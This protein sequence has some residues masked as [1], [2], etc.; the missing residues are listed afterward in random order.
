MRWRGREHRVAAVAL[1][2]VAVVLVAVDHDLVADL[3]A[4]DL[5]ADRP[6]DAG[7]VGAGDVVRALWTSNGEIGLPSPAQTPL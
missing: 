1:L 3:P 2:V 7:R 4:L 6:D 5:G